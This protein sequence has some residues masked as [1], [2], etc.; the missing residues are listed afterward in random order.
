MGN[1]WAPCLKG[2]LL[3]RLLQELLE[4]AQFGLQGRLLARHLRQAVLAAGQ[5]RLRCRQLRGQQLLTL[6]VTRLQLRKLDRN[7]TIFVYNL[8]PQTNKIYITYWNLKYDEYIMLIGTTTLLTVLDVCTLYGIET[9][10]YFIL[11]NHLFDLRLIPRGYR[12]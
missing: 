10:F 11:K 9:C 7:I 2:E 1:L 6:L 8:C 12:L 4:A 3:P 5:L